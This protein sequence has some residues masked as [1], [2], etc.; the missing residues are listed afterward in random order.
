MSES[1]SEMLPAVGNLRNRIDNNLKLSIPKPN[2]NFSPNRHS[3][4][5]PVAQNELPSHIPDMAIVKNIKRNLER[6]GSHDH[7]YFT[8]LSSPSSVAKISNLKRKIFFCF[9]KF[10]LIYF[11]YTEQSPIS[12]LID[13]SSPSSRFMMFGSHDFNV[14]KFS[15]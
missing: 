6:H 1:K 7:G 12:Q 11:K 10:Y 15:F 13:A 5:A 14:S 4:T 3:S 9:N 8:P 2:T